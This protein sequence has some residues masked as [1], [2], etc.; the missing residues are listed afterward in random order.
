MLAVPMDDAARDVT[1]VTT[2]HTPGSPGAIGE[3]R[4]SGS[5]L[6]CA[7]SEP[8]VVTLATACVFYL[9]CSACGFIW[10]VRAPAAIA[11]P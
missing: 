10:I 6:C 11:A 7:T 8:P 2:A 3:S 9:R 1:D 4:C 5:C